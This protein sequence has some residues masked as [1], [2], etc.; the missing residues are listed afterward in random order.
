MWCGVCGVVWCGCGCVFGGVCVAAEKKTSVDLNTPPC[1]HSKRLRVYRHHVT[2][3]NLHVPTAEIHSRSTTG[4]V[5]SNIDRGKSHRDC[6]PASGVRHHGWHPNFPAGASDESRCNG[7]VH[8]LH[9]PEFSVKCGHRAT[10]ST[11][12]TSTR[13]VKSTESRRFPPNCCGR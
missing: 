5:C 3:A 10:S 1:V 9:M 4:A 2:S 6:M 11:R 12:T 8:G 7:C 13:K